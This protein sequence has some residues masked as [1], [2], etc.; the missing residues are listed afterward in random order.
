MIIQRF[1]GVYVALIREKS[2]GFI[3]YGYTASR[4]IADCLAKKDNWQKKH[5]R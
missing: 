4:A 5:K 3:G 2:G 1:A